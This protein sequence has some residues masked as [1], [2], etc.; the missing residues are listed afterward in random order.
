MVSEDRSHQVA[1]KFDLAKLDFPSYRHNSRPF[2]Q[3]RA[4]PTRSR[5]YERTTLEHSFDKLPT[6]GR[7]AYQEDV[8]LRPLSC[9]GRPHRSEW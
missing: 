3:I 6:R 2:H 8:P 7:G 5:R 1:L 9:R 4:L